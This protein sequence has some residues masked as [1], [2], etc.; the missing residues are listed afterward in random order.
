MRRRINK[1][2]GTRKKKGRE[3]E[4]Q[5][6]QKICLSPWLRRAGIK[7]SSIFDLVK[8]TVD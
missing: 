8:W 1:E 5:R 3:I 7:M 2:T 4:K 6:E